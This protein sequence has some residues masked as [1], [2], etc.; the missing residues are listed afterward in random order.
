[1]KK[2]PTRRDQATEDFINRASTVKAD[3]PTYPRAVEP[4]VR[5]TFD[6]PADLHQEFKVHAT[7]HGRTMREIMVELIREEIRINKMGPNG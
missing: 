5:F 3:R 6:C 7:I 2:K 4:T 1:M